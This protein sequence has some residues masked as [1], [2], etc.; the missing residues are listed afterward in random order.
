MMLLLTLVLLILAL[1]MRSPQQKTQPSEAPTWNAWN[2]G[3]GFC[4]D[5]SRKVRLRRDGTCLHCGSAS[6]LVRGGLRCH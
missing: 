6:I 4:V 5:C 3:A 2:G 1:E